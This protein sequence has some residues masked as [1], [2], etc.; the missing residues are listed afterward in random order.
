MQNVYFTIKLTN[1]IRV[2]VTRYVDENWVPIIDDYKAKVGLSTEIE[3][4]CTNEQKECETDLI[5]GYKTIYRPY[6]IWNTRILIDKHSKNPNINKES[7]GFGQFVAFFSRLVSNQKG[8]FL[9][10]K[11]VHKGEEKIEKLLIAIWQK[12]T[13][14][15]QELSVYELPQLLQAPP[16]TLRGR[17]TAY[18]GKDFGI[19]RSVIYIGVKPTQCSAHINLK[20]VFC[21]HV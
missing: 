3:D 5:H 12:M 6:F 2:Q 4:A 19:P 7:F 20:V 18:Q 10:G 17:T 14:T 8:Y 1:F 11:K 16:D 13:G 9:S 15:D 21:L